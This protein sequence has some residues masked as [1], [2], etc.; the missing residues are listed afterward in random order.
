MLVMCTVISLTVHSNTLL[1]SAN[2]LLPPPSGLA[3][4][5]WSKQQ[6]SLCT[7]FAQLACTRYE[8][9][10]QSLTYYAEV[11]IC[12]VTLYMQYLP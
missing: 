3:W 8:D 1:A 6:L 2:E 5:H 10:C 12:I 11:G 4:W 9:H 7:A